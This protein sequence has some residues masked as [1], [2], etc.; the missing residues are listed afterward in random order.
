MLPHKRSWNAVPA[1]GQRR[2]W[3]PPAFG[4]PVLGTWA[5]R[6]VTQEEIP[7]KRAQFPFPGRPFS[8]GAFM[9][10]RAIVDNSLITKKVAFYFQLSQELNDCLL[11]CLSSLQKERIGY[12]Y[13]H[14]L[15][16]SRV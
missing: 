1:P 5:G 4:T 9:R 7:G 10:Q 3:A 8:G 6:K 16:P 12:R 2:A 11:A 14:F 13:A 15:L